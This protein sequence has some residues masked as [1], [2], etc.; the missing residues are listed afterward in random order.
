M[1]LKTSGL[2]SGVSVFKLFFFVTDT[3]KLERLYM[4]GFKASS[5]F[6]SNGYLPNKFG[7]DKH[8]RL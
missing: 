4:R 7:R 8:S 5:T 2:S 6:V 3:N 1:M